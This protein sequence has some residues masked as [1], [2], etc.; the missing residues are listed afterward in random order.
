[1]QNN[2]KKKTRLMK[3]R[4]QT[5]SKN[6]VGRAAHGQKFRESLKEAQDNGVARAYNDTPAVLSAVSL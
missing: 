6:Q 3:S 4:K 1:M 5:L 2:I